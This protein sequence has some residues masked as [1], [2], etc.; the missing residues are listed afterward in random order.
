MKVFNLR[1][2]RHHEFEGWFPSAEESERQ[3]SN[4]LTHCPICDCSDLM[5]MPSA[6]R[7]N[8]ATESATELVAPNAQAEW[9]KALRELIANTEDVGPRFA[10]EARRIHYRETPQRAI[11][12]V[13]SDRDRQELQ[14]EG[15]EV[16]ALPVPALAKEPLQ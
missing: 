14:E 9:V 7:L 13:A 5:R 4:H 2:S 11:R 10:E 3:L 8:L 16:I 12:G 15:I 1:C 6:P